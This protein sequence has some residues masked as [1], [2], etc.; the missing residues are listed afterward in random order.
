MKDRIRI[1]VNLW[2]CGKACRR[3]ADVTLKGG[4]ECVHSSLT[5]LYYFLLIHSLRLDESENGFRR[6]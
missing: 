6:K 1:I 4:A 3:D 2:E 5:R